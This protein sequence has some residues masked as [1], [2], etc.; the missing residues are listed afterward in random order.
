MIVV[1]INILISVNKK[2]LDKAKTMLHSFRR[3]HSEDITVYLINHS[4][5]GS[6][7]NKLRKYLKKHLRMDFFVIDVS[8]TAF[9]QLPLDTSRFSIEIYYRVIAQFLLP[10]TVE[11]I[12]WLDADI[13]LCGN[14]SEFY[15]QDFEGSL[16]AVCPDVNCE[17]KDI[18]LI[19]ESL[20]LSNEHIYFNSGV[21][22][23]N[24]EALRKTTTFHEIVQSAQAIAQHLVFP[25]QDLLNYY[26][27]G[28]VKYCNQ[29]QYNFQVMDGVSLTQAQIND[30]VILH[31]AGPYKPWIF[32][33]LHDL[34][35]A[36]IPYWREV[37]LRGK[38]LSIIKIGVLYALWLVYYKT[39][40]CNFVRKIMLK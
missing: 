15:Y 16:L 29:N 27:T 23:F 21:L 4:L 2:Y 25:D 11:R 31:Y 3:N 1:M 39:G 35:R 5:C 20:G 13:V 9:D 10:Q 30:I 8:I 34:S 26:Y 14:I 40:I 28:R 7:I 24:I 18:I 37:A 22:L 6:E 33:Y 32:Y 12:L 38:W 17:D 19:K 36:A